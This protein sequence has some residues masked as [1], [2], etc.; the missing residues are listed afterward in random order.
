MDRYQ[1]AGSF[2]VNLTNESTNPQVASKICGVVCLRTWIDESTRSAT[3]RS[4]TS[5][6]KFSVRESRWS[7]DSLS[8]SLLARGGKVV[9]YDA[10]GRPHENT[11]L[12]WSTAQRVRKELC[13][14]HFLVMSTLAVPKIAD[15]IVGESRPSLHL[16]PSIH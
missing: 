4:R 2:T 7:T 12:I 9:S 8:P 14:S 5:F 16:S 15:S 10:M 1:N 13:A 3:A 6:D 11:T